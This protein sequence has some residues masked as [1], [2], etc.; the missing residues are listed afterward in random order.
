MEPD[1]KKARV[2]LEAK[3]DPRKPENEPL[4]KEWFAVN[5]PKMFRTFRDRVLALVEPG[6]NE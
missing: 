2:L 4:V 5:T 3:I 6:T 1:S